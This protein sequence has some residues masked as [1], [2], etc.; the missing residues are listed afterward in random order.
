M[1]QLRPRLSVVASVFSALCSI[2]RSRSH[3]RL[4]GTL[5]ANLRHLPSPQLLLHG[6]GGCTLRHVSNAL[7]FGCPERR[8]LFASTPAGHAT[9]VARTSHPSSEDAKAC[10][11]RALTPVL[12]ACPCRPQA[13]R[14]NHRRSCA[15]HGVMDTAS[16][17]SVRSRHLLSGSRL[18][19]R[20]RRFRNRL[21]GHRPSGQVHTISARTAGPVVERDPTE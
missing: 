18:S 14:P 11:R 4:H 7:T 12:R 2:V 13:T 21:R 20:H 5:P 10:E 1:L 3:T 6:R 8:S 17:S 19:D 16:S 9:S 15:A